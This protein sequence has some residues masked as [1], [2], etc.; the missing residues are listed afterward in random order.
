M[1]FYF[2]S[3][4]P[5][6]HF[7][8]FF[9]Y[10]SQRTLSN[11]IDLSPRIFLEW[12]YIEIKKFPSSMS[13]KCLPFKN[14]D[15]SIFNQIAQNFESQIRK[16]ISKIYDEHHNFIISNLYTIHRILKSNI[17][18]TEFFKNKEIWIFSPK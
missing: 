7:N 18:A 9:F 4:Y 13:T 17:F 12:P 16:C 15:T 8:N 11:K 3:V 5:D 10:N 2:V 14:D 6:R 1:E